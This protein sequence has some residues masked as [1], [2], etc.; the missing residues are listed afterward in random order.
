MKVEGK[1][2]QWACV[3]VGVC[4]LV[5][6]RERLGVEIMLSMCVPYGRTDQNEFAMLKKYVSAKKHLRP[7][8]LKMSENLKFMN[9]FYFLFVDNVIKIFILF[10]YLTQIILSVIKS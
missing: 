2:I 7:F 9:F 5:R 6:E 8:R 4:R 3:G 10:V 1:T